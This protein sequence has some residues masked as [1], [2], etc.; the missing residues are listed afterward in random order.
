[1]I[2]Y[3]KITR[4]ITER[5]EAELALERA[6]E[7]LFQSQKL[8]AIG[9][10]TGGVAH[11]FN[12]VLNVIVN[13]MEI[14]AREAQTPSS[15]RMLESM[16]RAAAQ[17]TAL[18]Q[19]LLAFARKQPLQQD[20]C[21]LN[22]VIRSFEPML[23]KASKGCVDFSLEL[24]PLLPAVIIDVSKLE[25]ALLNLIINAR[26]ATPDG[27][28][29]TLSTAQVNLRENKVGELPAG[30]YVKVTVRDTGHGMPPEVAA[31]AVEPFFTTKEVGK[32]TGLGLSQV[33]GTIKQFGGEIIIET[34]VG[35]GTTISLILPVLEGIAGKN[36]TD[37]PQVMERD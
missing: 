18:T 6:K 30:R 28:A 14:L 13:G 21:D 31:Q 24:D 3:V 8:D 37:R 4:D 17:G 2:G 5:R 16:K 34:A 19:Q 26:D 11:D 12:N 10:L 22:Q 27:G 36:S 32:G 35:E 29:I 1:M 15:I 20:T 9:N 7:A 23:E 25:A 33:Y